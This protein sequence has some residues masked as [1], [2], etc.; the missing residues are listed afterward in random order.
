[1]YSGYRII[2]DSAV[3]WS[4]DNGIARNVRNFRLDYNSSCHADNC[5]N[6]F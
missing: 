4:F 1:M 5:K 2:F 6:N 3:S